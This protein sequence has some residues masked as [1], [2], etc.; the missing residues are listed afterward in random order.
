MAKSASGKFSLYGYNSVFRASDIPFTQAAWSFK[1]VHSHA[2]FKM[3]YFAASSEQEMKLWMLR[4]KEEMVTANGKSLDYGKFLQAPIKEEKQNPQL[5]KDDASFYNDVETNI[6]DDSTKFS[7]TKDYQKKCSVKKNDE[8]SDDDDLPP[9]NPAID[10][11][12]P[13]P[14]PI[15]KDP[16]VTLSHVSRPQ[17]PMPPS[18][19]HNNGVTYTPVNHHHV[20][21]NNPPL[22]PPRKRSGNNDS[23]GA[24][25]EEAGSFVKNLV[26]NPTKK[27][28]VDLRDKLKRKPSYVKTDVG[29]QSPPPDDVKM[30]HRSFFDNSSQGEEEPEDPEKYWDSAYF[31]DSDKNRANDIIQAL[32]EEGVYMVRPETTGQGKVLV[33]YANDQAKKYRIKRT[34]D[35]K[36]CLSDDGY[37]DELLENVL[38]YYYENTL[39]TVDV[40]LKQPFK[41]H[42]RYKS[43]DI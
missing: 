35:H 34:K 21:S 1:I 27:G 33:V 9:F 3:Y 38:Y 16:F 36:F 39:P 11:R 26:N 5:F 30:D 20:T 22:T 40:R 29:G 10:N 31:E 4:V 43:L 24:T 32:A 28:S 15:N 12:A 2:E 19:I 25:N 37:K 14:V 6:Y 13:V 41:L 18:R 42:P 23:Q 7:P 17:D 8:D